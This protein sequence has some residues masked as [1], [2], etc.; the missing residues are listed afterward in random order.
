MTKNVV[1]LTGAGIS[2]ESGLD[3]FRGDTGLWCNHNVNDVASID[4]F[5]RNPQL[6]HEFYRERYNDIKSATQNDAHKVLSVLEDSSKYNVTVITQNIDDLHERAG[7]Q[8][9]IHVHGSIYERKCLE[10][11]TISDSTMSYQ[12]QCPNC[13]GDTRP[14]IVWFGENIMHLNECIAAVKECDI[15]ISIGTSGQVYPVA[16]FVSLANSFGATTFELNLE[17]TANSPKYHFNEY[18]QASIIVCAM[19]HRL[20]YDKIHLN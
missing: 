8:K 16:E 5:L 11:E 7:S 9:V 10:C 19:V 6:V 12:T 3:T 4:G 18:G 1:I 15:F 2:A 20:I 13:G 14:N 17:K